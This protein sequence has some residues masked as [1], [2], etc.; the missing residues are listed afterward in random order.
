MLET[1]EGWEHRVRERAYHLWREAGEPAGRDAE[2]WSRAELLEAEAAGDA[3]E[4]AAP[5]GTVKETGA[6]QPAGS[7][8]A[9]A[10]GAK[11]KAGTKGAASAAK[12]GPAAKA[13]SKAAKAAAAPQA[14]LPGEEKSARPGS[15][16]A[17][18]KTASKGKAFG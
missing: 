10:G 8:P 12:P 2:F 17:G 11:A 3:G 13:P 4:A 7:A 14:P 16:A 5:P 15:A 1:G 18:A 9:T 6:Q